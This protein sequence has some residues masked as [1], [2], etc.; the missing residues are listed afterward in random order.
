MIE[1]ACPS[2][3][4]AGQVPKEKLQ[5]RLVCRKCHMVFHVD[6]QGR[7]VLGEPVSAKEKTKKEAEPKSILK[8]LG[9]PT[10]EQ[11]THMGDDL[12][13]YTFPVK[14]AAGLVGGLVGLWLI[15]GFVSGPGESVADT[16]RTVAEA[17][18]HDDL[19]RLKTLATDDT[20]DDMI[21]FYDAAHPKLEKARGGWPSKDAN[22]QVVVVEEDLKT[23]KGETEVF[24]LPAASGG[25]T[26]SV[27]PGAPPPPMPPP[28]AP[29]PGAPKSDSAA[30]TPPPSGPF[31]L[32]LIWLRSGKHWLLDG[33][34]SAAMAAHQPMMLSPGRARG[35]PTH[36]EVLRAR[37]AHPRSDSPQG[38]SI[39]RCSRAD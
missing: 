3:G 20:R 1:M 10:L 14:P 38:P 11:M 5:T 23:G 32:H 29:V 6:S 7:P 17:L 4:R 16:S 19:N 30:A 8:A 25:P 37:V 15:W 13:D 2:C 9:I 34:A 26:A 27:A 28:T 21:R 36:S 12:S 39:V 24:Y 31:S 22:I 35:P 18:A 33:R